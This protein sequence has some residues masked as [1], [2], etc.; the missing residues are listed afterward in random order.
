MMWLS[1]WSGRDPTAR[2]STLIFSICS[3]WPLTTVS[4]YSSLALHTH[5]PD[6]FFL[7]FTTTNSYSS[8]SQNTCHTSNIQG[9]INWG[10][11]ES[12]MSTHN[13]IRNSVSTWR[14]G[15]VSRSEGFPSWSQVFNI[16]SDWYSS[17]VCSWCWLC[18][19]AN[20]M[21]NSV[22]FYFFTYCAFNYF[23]LTYSVLCFLS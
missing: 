5:L 17:T 11:S 7:V 6:L 14:S 8:L 22:K 13:G 2:P 23:F 1:S 15:L 9:N 19:F 16:F 20:Y 21:F 3:C 4:S 10:F 18:K 12:S